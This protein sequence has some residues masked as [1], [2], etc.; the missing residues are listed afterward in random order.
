V[1]ALGLIYRSHV[2]L[3]TGD[4]RQG[5]VHLDEAGAATLAGTVSPWVSGVV[6][7]SVIWAYLDRGDINRAGQWTDQFTRWVKRNAAYGAPGLCRLHRGEVMC[8]R[9]DL[10]AAETEIHQARELLAGSARY[11]E[12]DACRVLGEIRLLRGELDGAD[13]AFRQAHELGWHPLPGW[14]L[15][16]AKRGRL[17]V[18]IKTLQRGLQNPSWAD[19]QRRGILLA[20]LVRFAA[21]NGQ[22][23]LARKNLAELENAAD[24]RAAAG[25]EAAYHEAV[26][27]LAL[28]DQ[29]PE[30]AIEALRKSLTIWLEIGS[31]INVAHIR[32][33]LAEILAQG[34]DFDD[35]D[36]ELSSAEKAFEKMGAKPMVACCRASRK[37]A[38]AA[39]RRAVAR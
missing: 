28:A 11:A 18:A 30:K 32:L 17:A 25:C 16:Q 12:G 29:Q 15:L 24:L 23:P 4:I 39:A 1:E 31:R 20:H 33:R 38:Q 9:G 19:G 2:E 6:F 22:L 7:C 8:L 3:A 5:L 26:A 21:Q 34:G 35:A 36:L 10:Q 14:A 13:E 37:S 27:E